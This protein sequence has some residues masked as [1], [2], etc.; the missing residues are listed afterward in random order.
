MGSEFWAYY[1]VI[2]LAIYL[3]IIP[4]PN[5]L[6]SSSST[7]CLFP[8]SVKVKKV[9]R[10]E[11]AEVVR[12]RGRCFGETYLQILIRRLLIL[13]SHRRWAALPKHPNHDEQRE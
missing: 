6:P 9:V 13:L 7:S 10:Q 5:I 1:S 3:S 8:L 2:K 11:K 4:I 12:Q